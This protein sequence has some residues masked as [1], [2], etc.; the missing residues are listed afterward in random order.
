[1]VMPVELQCRTP[2]GQ[3]VVVEVNTE[4]SCRIW[5]RF[6][7]RSI[8]TLGDFRLRQGDR[9]D[10]G[11]GLPPEIETFIAQIRRRKSSKKPDA[12]LY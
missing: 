2:A 12:R 6:I 3:V 5:Q 4:T 8:P 10:D 9:T 7:I 11:R 1:M